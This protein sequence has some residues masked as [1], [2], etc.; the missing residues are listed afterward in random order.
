M[1]LK[2]NVRMTYKM[3][4]NNFKASYLFTIGIHKTTIYHPLI[5]DTSVCRVRACSDFVHFRFILKHVQTC[6]C[7]CLCVCACACVPAVCMPAYVCGN[8][9]LCLCMC[10]CVCMRECEGRRCLNL[11]SAIVQFHVVKQD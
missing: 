4:F 6:V 2:I 7:L 1:Y 8:V 10:V 11:R 9:C 5:L 3:P